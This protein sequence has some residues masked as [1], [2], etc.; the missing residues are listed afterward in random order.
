MFSY[1]LFV[2]GAAD[3]E[4]RQD[5]ELNISYAKLGQSLEAFIPCEIISDDNWKKNLVNCPNNWLVYLANTLF[6]FYSECERDKSLYN[7]N[8]FL[9]TLSKKG[10]FIPQSRFYFDE[11]LNNK[12]VEYLLNQKTDY[13]NKIDYIVATAYELVQRKITLN[14]CKEC[15]KWFV[16]HNKIDTLYCPYCATAR[17]KRRKA[18]EQLATK[19][20]HNCHVRK[21]YNNDYTSEYYKKYED[22]KNAVVDKKPDTKTATLAEL[23]EYGEWLKGIQKTEFPRIKRGDK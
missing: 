13:Q 12:V 15:G 10:Y 2:K 8:Y 9:A 3:K 20:Q 17:T 4:I 22:I 14:K 19:I 1:L 16:A 6:E 7:E 18:N 5:K 11:K 23:I 21:S